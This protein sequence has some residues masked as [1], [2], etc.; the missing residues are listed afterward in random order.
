MQIFFFI[1][2]Q[3]MMTWCPHIDVHDSN[4]PYFIIPLIVLYFKY[5][6]CFPY[7]V[8]MYNLF[9]FHITYICHTWYLNRRV[10]KLKHI[11]VCYW[12]SILW[13]CIMIIIIHVPTMP[14]CPTWTNRGVNN[15]I[16]FFPPEQIASTDCSDRCALV[17]G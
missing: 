2:L 11:I 10:N 3:E 7:I 17:W 15:S 12:F 8:L 5:K 4:T 14:V 1:N 9:S 13:Y 6:S 16:N